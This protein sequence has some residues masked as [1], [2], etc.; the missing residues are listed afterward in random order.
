M[1]LRRRCEDSHPED[2]EIIEP[3]A[4]RQPHRARRPQLLIRSRLDGRTGPAKLFDRLTKKSVK[5]FGRELPFANSRPRLPNRNIIA[6]FPGQKQPN[7]G[8]SNHHLG[9]KTSLHQ[10]DK[11]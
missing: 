1:V 4:K 10:C 2:A 6:R 5:Y 11:D 3:K 9:W 7:G 8:R